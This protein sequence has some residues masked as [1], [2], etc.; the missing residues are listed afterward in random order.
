MKKRKLE[1]E[2]VMIN[3]SKLAENKIGFKIKSAKVLF[4]SFLNKPK[5]I[6]LI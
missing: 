3:D 6:W 4:L 2:L 1:Q 5:V